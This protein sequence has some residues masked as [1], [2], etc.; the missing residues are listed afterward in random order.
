MPKVI[1]KA[2]PSPGVPGRFVLGAGIRQKF[3]P[4]GSVEKD[5]NGNPQYWPA[6]SGV[7]IPAGQDTELTITDE[8]LRDLQ[9]GANAQ[10]FAV[11]VTDES[12]QPSINEGGSSMATQPQPAGSPPPPNQPGTTV[13]PG[14]QPSP[15]PTPPTPQGPS[16]TGEPAPSTRTTKR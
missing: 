9:S 1:V 13:P 3:K 8:E 12:A 5:A 7:F 11:V 2:T 16:P 4:D 10:L 15:T 6:R 14:T